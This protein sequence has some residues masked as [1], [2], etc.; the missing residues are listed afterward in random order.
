MK[1]ILF[2]FISIIFLYFPSQAGEPTDS[3]HSKKK[4]VL[5]LLVSNEC[6]FCERLKNIM[7][8]DTAFS[9]SINEKFQILKLTIDSDEGKLMA[10]RWMVRKVPAFIAYDPQTNQ[11][12]VFTGFSSAAKLAGLLQISYSLLPA[13]QRISQPDAKNLLACGDGVLDAGESCDDANNNNAD[14]C[15]SSCNIEPGFSCAGSPSVCNTLCG[16]GIVAGIEQCDDNNMNNADGCTSVCTIEVGFQ[17]TGTPSICSSICGDG[18][19]TGNETCDDMNTNFNDGCS[20]SCDIETGYVCIG[21]PSVC[22]SICGDG[23]IAGIEGCDDGNGISGDGCSSSCTIEPGY[24]CSGQPSACTLLPVCGNG[25]IEASESCD[26]MNVTNGD[27]CSSS[28]SI[29]P[30]Y[31]CTGV[32]SVCIT[33]CGNGVL[34]NGEECDDSNTTSGD[35][36]NNVCM[37]ETIPQGVAVNRDNTRPHPSS[38]LDVKSNDK[39]ILI[40]RLS[41]SQRTAIT[42]PAK[43]L[44]VFDTT[45]GSFWFYNGTIWKQ[46]ATL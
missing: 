6:P 46:L 34:D 10:S 21:V 14:G 27:G 26:D 33:N 38:M 24:E 18:I 30:T 17:C 37:F 42:N 16:D 3:N 8:N 12:Q 13:S 20:S 1:Q 9:K 28:C 22:N 35:G 43:G 39:G 11:Q 25:V 29:E 31:I 23:I 36:C 5:V 4:P 19:I 40:P 45:T 32:P 41:S 44:L 2:I 15:S 7:E